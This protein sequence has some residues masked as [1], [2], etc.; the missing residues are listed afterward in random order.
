MTIHAGVKEKRKFVPGGVWIS[1]SLF[2]AHEREIGTFLRRRGHDREVVADLIQ[3]TFVRV[4]GMR[5]PETVENARGFLFT[6]AA[7][8][9]RDH[10]RRLLRRERVEAGP[11]EDSIACTLPTP[12]EALCRQQQER[13]LQQAIDSLPEMTREVFLL[14]HVEGCSYREIAERLELSSRT[15]EY[16]L[17]HALG[18]CRE[19]VRRL[20]TL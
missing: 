6:V 5:N 16:R 19:Y 8:L 2:V 7:N 11:V 10:L 1:K 9:A 14:Y 12:E 15:V 17:R 18:L 3:D 13:V 20:G 4:A